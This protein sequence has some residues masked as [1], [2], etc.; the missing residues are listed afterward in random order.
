M[1]DH[2]YIESLINT[3]QT[4]QKLLENEMANLTAAGKSCDSK[5][6]R[7]FIVD[8]VLAEFYEIRSNESEKNANSLC[9]KS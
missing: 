1:I 4:E 5:Q 3:Y 2:D 7:L 6:S 9:S 8:T